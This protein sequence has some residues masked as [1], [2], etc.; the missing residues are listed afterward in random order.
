[1]KTMPVEPQ[2][3]RA[4]FTGRPVG[5]DRKNEVLQGYVVAQEGPFKSEGR[6]EFDEQSLSAIVRLGNAARGGLKSR[7]THPDLSSDGLGKFLGRV[8]DFSMSQATDARTGRRVKAVR[9]DLHFDKSAHSTPSGDL[10]KYVMDLAESDPEALS[11]SI[12]VKPELEYRRKKDGT[13]EKDADGNELPP[14]WRPLE[15]H[16]SD[17]VDT[18][19]AV[20]G[21]LSADQLTA[22]LSVGLT[23]ELQAAL[24]WDNVVRL[25][26]QMLD[27]LFSGQ[28]REV[29]EARCSAYLARYLARRYG[30]EEPAAEPGE[31]VVPPAP[32][33]R[34]DAAGDRLAGVALE[35]ETIRLRKKQ[36]KPIQD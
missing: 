6:G 36:A 14:L 27:G 22:A 21:L 19:D 33:P 35:A 29:V 16:A 23:P 26:G 24:K 31:P 13:L 34:L 20:D 4:S 11:S 30:G 25:A 18:G 9:A 2:Y 1:M 8:R 7:F 28:S 17:I 15:L 10:A 5:V 12:V 3:L 32:R